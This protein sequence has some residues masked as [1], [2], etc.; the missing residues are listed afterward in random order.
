MPIDSLL[1]VSV[2]LTLSILDTLRTLGAGDPDALLETAGIDPLLLQKPENRIPLV[3]QQ[4][5]WQL[6]AQAS[7]T[8]AFGL[9]FAASNPPTLVCWAIWR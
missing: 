3:Q 9:H 7:G 5:L 2:G 8:P 6:A 1:E 4:A